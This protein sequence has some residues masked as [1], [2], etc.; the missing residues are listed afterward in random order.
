MRN[1]ELCCRF[2]DMGGGRKGGNGRPQSRPTGTVNGENN[3]S[4]IAVFL[5]T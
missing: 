4:M 1:L 3:H 2:E 5:S